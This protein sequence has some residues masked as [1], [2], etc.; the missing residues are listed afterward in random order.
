M[1]IITSTRAEIPDSNWQLSQD[2]MLL[3][4]QESWG[5]HWYISTPPTSGCWRGHVL[6]CPLSKSSP[7]SP[8]WWWSSGHRL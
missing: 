1:C 8:R 2:S 3:V 7:G 4:G 5:W 6:S